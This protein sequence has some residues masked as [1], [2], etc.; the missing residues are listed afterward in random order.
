MPRNKI[1]H[2][3]SPQPF[4]LIDNFKLMQLWLLPFFL[5]NHAADIHCSQ[6]ADIDKQ[7]EVALR[8]QR[9]FIASHLVPYYTIVFALDDAR[10][11]TRRIDLTAA[12]NLRHHIESN[13]L[14][15]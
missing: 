9:N 4:K 2:V 13:S 3:R 8:I 6:Y 15:R 14:W 7:R 1:L 12:L 11:R 5:S 10:P